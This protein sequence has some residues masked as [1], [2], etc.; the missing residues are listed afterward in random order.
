ML[1][2]VLSIQVYKYNLAVV[3]IKEVTTKCE[4]NP[5]L[6]D[7]LGYRCV[8]QWKEEIVGVAHFSG[9]SP[10][11]DREEVALDS[12]SIFTAPLSLVLELVGQTGLI[13]LCF[14]HKLTRDHFLL[15]HYLVFELIFKRCV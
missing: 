13:S 1:R 3:I 11:R 9:A 7:G 10:R 6:R 8:R 15:V 5:T 14:S 12:P 2:I 4:Y